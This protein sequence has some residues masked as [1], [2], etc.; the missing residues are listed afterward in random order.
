MIGRSNEV[1]NKR[2]V[3]ALVG[4]ALVLGF[5]CVYKESFYVLEVVERQL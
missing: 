3:I 5:Q 1:Q 2:M 4:I